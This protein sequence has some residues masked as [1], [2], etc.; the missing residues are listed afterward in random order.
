MSVCEPLELPQSLRKEEQ[1]ELLEFL[2]DE[3]GGCLWWSRPFPLVSEIVPLLS[4]FFF[5]CVDFMV[6]SLL[7][8]KLVIQAA[9][10]HGCPFI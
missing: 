3:Q 2:G 9:V 7:S 10:W 4:F 1:P 8:V 6:S 5:H